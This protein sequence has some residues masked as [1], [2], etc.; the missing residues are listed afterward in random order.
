ME[1]QE[2]LPLLNKAYR[3]WIESH[4]YAALA[5]PVLEEIAE[6]GGPSRNDPY[7]SRES[8][9]GYVNQVDPRFLPREA[10][11]WIHS[12]PDRYRDPDAGKPHPSAAYFKNQGRWNR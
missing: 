7:W 3:R 10:V 9:W 11:E 12:L 1:I 4:P 2:W 8:L 6:V 5:E